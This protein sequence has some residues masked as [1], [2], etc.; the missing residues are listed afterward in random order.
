MKKWAV[1]DNEKGRPLAFPVGESDWSNHD[2]WCQPPAPNLT[3]IPPL[4]ELIQGLVR[5]QNGIYESPS[6]R[7]NVLPFG[8]RIWRGSDRGD[9]KHRCV[10][11][12]QSNGLCHTGRNPWRLGQKESWFCF[13][14]L[15]ATKLF[16]QVWV[17]FPH[18]C[19]TSPLG[20]E[21]MD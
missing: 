10:P 13:C 11:L 19:L 21:K 6:F 7:L 5:L 12:P 15:R 17:K 9:T 14:F 20:H 2:E 4:W 18:Y 1:D 3:L 16:R 8:T